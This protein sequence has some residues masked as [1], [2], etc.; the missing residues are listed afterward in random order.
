ML[1]SGHAHGVFA[2]VRDTTTI[3]LSWDRINNYV[4]IFIQLQIKLPRPKDDEFMKIKYCA[5]IAWWRTDE[6]A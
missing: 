6:G 3:P 5:T 4:Q 1:F 2:Q